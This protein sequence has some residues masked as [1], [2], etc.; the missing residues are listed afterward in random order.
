MEIKRVGALNTWVTAKRVLDESGKWGE[1][2]PGIK[3][4]YFTLER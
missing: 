2:L 4:S 3:K 1:I